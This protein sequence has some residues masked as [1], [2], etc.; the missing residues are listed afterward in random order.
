MSGQSQAAQRPDHPGGSPLKRALLAAVMATVLYGAILGFAYGVI[1]LLTGRDVISEPDV[2]PLIGP[3]MAAVACVLVFGSVLMSLRPR[4]GPLRLPWGRA[5]TTAIA[6]YLLGPAVGALLVAVGRANAFSGLL[7][8]GGNITGPFVICSAIVA[9]PLV[10]A[11]PL[12]ASRGQTP[13]V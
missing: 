10:L 2:G 6:V 12:L 5:V 4:R 13:G 1:S 3:V 9:L 7:F 8:F 11:V